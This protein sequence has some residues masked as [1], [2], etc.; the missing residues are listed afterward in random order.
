MDKIIV[1][2][3]KF[4]VFQEAVETGRDLAL[5]HL[6]CNRAGVWF[7]I[8]CEIFNSPATDAKYKH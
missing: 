1:F 2:S 3:G 8:T 4:Q 7:F 5:L 6:P